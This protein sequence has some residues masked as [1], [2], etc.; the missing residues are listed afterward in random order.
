MAKK[1]SPPLHVSQARI[2]MERVAIARRTRTRIGQLLAHA[3]E[4]NEEDEVA[5]TKIY[6]N[7]CCLIILCFCVL[8]VVMNLLFLQWLYYKVHNVKLQ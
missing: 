5:V 1:K 7:N 6:R 3:A 2:E 8:L 4:N